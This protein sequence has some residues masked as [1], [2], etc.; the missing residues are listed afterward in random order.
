MN[1]DKLWDSIEK[2]EKAS[3]GAEILAWTYFNPPGFSIAD[4]KG[5]FDTWSI[6]DFEKVCKSMQILPSLEAE[7][8]KDVAFGVDEWTSRID[9]YEG[10]NLQILPEFF[11]FTVSN[12]K[13]SKFF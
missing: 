7:S 12:P 4:I 9:Y 5:K 13:K 1:L 8:D 2:S 6:E 10:T 11:W 3:I